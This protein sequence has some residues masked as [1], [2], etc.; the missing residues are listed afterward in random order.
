MLLWRQWCERR[1]RHAGT[2][3]LRP[4]FS[5]VSVRLARRPGFRLNPL[6]GGYF[7]PADSP[8]EAFRQ[9]ARDRAGPRSQRF[10]ILSFPLVAIRGWR[11]GPR[12]E[13]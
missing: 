7:L 2:G 4:S 5:D 10:A 6:F 11:T 12:G 9:A 13:P 1:P 3:S 8:G